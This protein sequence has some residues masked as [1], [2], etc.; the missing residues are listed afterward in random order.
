MFKKLKIIGLSSRTDLLR[1]YVYSTAPMEKSRR[2]LVACHEV[3]KQVRGNVNRASG[4]WARAVQQHTKSLTY[5]VNIEGSHEGH[6]KRSDNDSVYASKIVPHGLLTSEAFGTESEDCSRIVLEKTTK[7]MESEYRNESALRK[8][9]EGVPLE[10]NCAGIRWKVDR[11]DHTRWIKN[12]QNN[13]SHH[14][15]QYASI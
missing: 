6:G 3:R 5:I 11:K 10:V 9:R 12:I 13:K 8:L 15:H 14:F 1:N 2:I 4:G 7:E